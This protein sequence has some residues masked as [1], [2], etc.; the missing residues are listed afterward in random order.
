MRPP[1]AITRALLCPGCLDSCR[2]NFYLC[3]T[4]AHRDLTAH[5]KMTTSSQT[6]PDAGR[7]VAPGLIL[8]LSVWIGLVAGFLD[9][10]AMV[11]KSR[12]TG[13]GF[14]HLGSHFVWIIPLGVAVLVLLP[15]MAL[16]LIAR[17]R[18]GAVP[19]GLAVG[20]LSLV[21]FLEISGRVPLALWSILLLC[22]GLAIQAARLASRNQQG[23]V[24]V[25]WRTAPLLVVV[26]AAVVLF[27]FGRL[28]W[29]EHKALAA[30]PTAPSG[31]RNVLL[32][33][34]DTVR[35]GNLS[36]HGYGR[37][38]TPN[39]ERLA[40][41]G[42]TF[43]SRVRDL[44]VDA[45]RRTPASSPAAGRMN[46][47]STGRRRFDETHLTLA[48]YL[49]SHGYD[50]AGFVANLEYCGRETGLDRGFAHYED[51]PI[52]AWDAFRRYIAIG[53]NVDF[54]SLACAANERLSRRPSGV[55]CRS[56]YARKSMSRMPPTSTERS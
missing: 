22:A 21:G 45:P 1:G 54:L 28:S 6:G 8:V 33:V 34:W 14:Y 32:I 52:A 26:E 11:L 50:T 48:E 40:G 18:R 42:V 23:F 19:L 35:A 13:M 53:R 29:S 24:K 2:L 38:T 36:L 12:L 56:L 17:L 16:A 41:R 9:L 43:R 15:G 39:L 51:Y 46:S 55:L 5:H 47:R 37:R 3:L 49:G 30:V 44:L 4:A 10:G 7:S 20:L 27:T 25:V 31:A